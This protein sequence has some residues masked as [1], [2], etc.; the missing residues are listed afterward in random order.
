MQLNLRASRLCRHLI[1]DAHWL[2]I[3]TTSA[4]DGPRVIDCGVDV[5][6]GLEAGRRLAEIC[7]SGLGS[8]RL[9]PGE[10]GLW[11]GPAVLVQTDQPVLGCMVSQYAGWEIKGERF[12]A[13]GSGPMRAVAGREPLLAELGYAEATDVAVGVLECDSMPPAAVCRDLADKCHVPLEGLTLLVAPTASLAGSVQIVARSVETAL[14]KLH[15]LSFDLARVES[16][17]GWAPLP[18]VGP[19]TA[20][21]RTNDAIIYGGQVVLYV[22][23]DDASAAEAAARTPSCTSAD[24]GRPF[25]E[26]FKKYDNDFYKVD[27]TLFSP[28]R[29]TL[30]NLDTGRSFRHGRALP[31]VINASFGA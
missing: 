10:P 8:V 12:F 30:V 11:D 20:I 14:H 7:L 26:I 13:M 24:F 17:V 21:G 31:E 4:D 15:E 27:R 16:G 23:G 18:P 2:R 6:G 22:R 29:V 5:P 3:R 19:G 9:V 1:R 28:A 25:A